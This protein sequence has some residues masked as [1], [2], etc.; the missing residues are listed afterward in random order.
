LNHAQALPQAIPKHAESH[1]VRVVRMT[2]GDREQIMRGRG[3]SWGSTGLI[4]E[5][6]SLVWAKRAG[7]IAVTANKTT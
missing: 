4:F 1:P 2:Y 7:M 6:M 3:R 5:S